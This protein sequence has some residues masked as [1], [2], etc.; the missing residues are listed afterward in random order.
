MRKVFVMVN[1]NMEIKQRNYWPKKIFF[2]S[3]NGCKLCEEHLLA[4]IIEAATGEHAVKYHGK[5]VFSCSG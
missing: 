1:N 2:K 5:G 4:H 3:I